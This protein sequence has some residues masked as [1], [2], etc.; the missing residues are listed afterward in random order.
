MKRLILMI[1]CA[2]VS[3]SAF[4]KWHKA[5]LYYNN[6]SVTTSEIKLPEET[7]GGQFKRAILI[8]DGDNENYL[9][10]SEISI[11]VLSTCTFRAGYPIQWH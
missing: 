11:V 8:K 1:A 10:I 4:A 5:V 9:G 6:G 7:F 3:V 2:V